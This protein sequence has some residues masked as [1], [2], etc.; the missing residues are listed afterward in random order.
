M[1]SEI[2][3]IIGEEEQETILTNILNRLL[4]LENPVEPYATQ[5]HVD[6]CVST[7][8]EEIDTIE[9]KNIEQDEKLTNIEEKDIAQDNRLSNIEIKNTEQDNRLSDIETKD[10]KQ[11]NRL[12]TIEA[13]DVEQNVRLVNI[14]SKNAEQ[15]NKLTSIEVKDV[16]QDERLNSLKNKVDSI[17]EKIVNTI[18]PTLDNYGNILDALEAKDI[19]HESRMTDIESK[20][21]KQDEKL[22]TIETKNIEQD[23]KLDSLEAKDLIYESK[24]TNIETKN[25]EQDGRLSIIEKEDIEQ[26]N[27]ITN[28]ESKNNQQDEK[29]NAIETKNTEQ[30]GR[31]DIAENRLANIGSDIPNTMQPIIDEHTSR[32]DAIEAID[33]S[34]NTRLDAIEVKNQ[35]QDDRLLDIEKVNKRQDI[36]IKCLY[37]ATSTV[38][39]IEEG[40]SVYL[41]NSNNGFTIVD[42]IKGNTLVNCNKEA[43]KELILNGNINTSGDNTVTLTEGVDGG[44]VDVALEGNTLVNVSKTK[45]STAITKAYTVENSG[46]HVALQGDTDGNCR[47]VITGKTLVNLF[48]EA[49]FKKTNY[50]NLIYWDGNILKTSSQAIDSDRGN[51]TLLSYVGSILKQ[52]TVYTFVIR[53][54]NTFKGS[55]FGNDFTTQ[56]NNEGDGIHKLIFTYDG[57]TNG[58]YRIWVGTNTPTDMEVE[59]LLLLEGDYTDKPIPDYFEGLQSTFEDNLVTQEMIDSGKEVADNLGKYRVEYKTTREDGTVGSTKTLYLNSPLLEGDTIEEKDNGIYHVHRSKEI[60]FDGNESLSIYTSSDLTNNGLKLFRLEYALESFGSNYYRKAK[61]NKFKCIQE[62]RYN[63][64]KPFIAYI[65]GDGHLWVSADIN[66]TKQDML[67]Y[68]NDCQFVY[69]LP[70]P[71]YELISEDSILC[72]SYVNGHLDF[73]SAVPVEKVEFKPFT[74]ELTYLYANTQYTLQFIADKAIAVDI[75]LGGTQLLAQ[76]I[77]AG[78]NRISITTPETL[79][80]NKLVISGV[81]AN[82]ME[83]VVTDIDR[84]LIYFEGMKSVGECEELQ[85]IST[86][87]DT[88][89]LNTQQLT[90]EPL[91]GTRDAKDR[92]VLIDG[93]WYIERKCGVRAYQEGDKDNYK[94]DL[95]NT[96][97]PLEMPTYEE[98]DYNPLEVYS[99][100]THIFTNSTIPTNITVKNHGFN[101]LLKPSTTY[102]I[103]SNLGL[104]TVTT[105]AKLTEDCLRFMDTDTSNVTTMKN[106]LVLEGDWTTKPHAIPANFSGIESAFEQEYDVEKGKYKVNVKVANE[107]KSK[108]NN[109][110]FYIDE[111]LRG[112][113]TAKDRVYVKDDK[114][115]VQ[116][117]CGIRP[118][119]DGD[120]GTY[121]TDKVDTIYPLAEP[122]YEEVEYDD[123]KLFI[124]SFKNSTLFYNSNVPVTSKLYYSYSVPIVDTVAQTANV[125]DQQDSMIIDLATQVAVMEMML[126]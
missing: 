49:N 41:Q 42:E 108:E 12:T 20:N 65:T 31:L 16:E 47:P 85:V 64:N 32:L 113:G 73:E 36:D 125:T 48:N 91:R 8:T 66:W 118:Y 77:V 78:L 89:L 123:T 72:N 97:Y 79:V 94:T 14:E 111:P 23:S 71:Q 99:G 76:S 10:I 86:N 126:M 1:A 117:N 105:P 17:D 43:D 62:N 96:V 80:D 104:N 107:D 115:V 90:H 75:T 37:G 18:E 50:T 6:E 19:S 116:R 68:I 110:T 106:V 3:G 58:S 25:T 15:D 101:C 24:I 35:Q 59:F 45:D 2:A 69:E 38:N 5:K 102:T 84:E 33:V 74:E 122:T 98:I 88:S 119:E 70:S 21:T 67:N 92:Y 61:S 40:N 52:D 44:L 93:K 51:I 28:I 4:T 55:I 112:T 63:I 109:I 46:N 95:I 100:T 7:L 34:Q 11:D 39:I 53:T 22:N 83:V 121:L 26:N 13:K 60:M 57:S 124:E 54:K 120:F 114:V 56:V 27:R 29:L 30:D 82:I 87:S 81:G 103:S 9:A